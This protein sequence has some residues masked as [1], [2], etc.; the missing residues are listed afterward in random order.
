L[1]A[2]MKSNLIA[3]FAAIACGSAAAADPQIY[4]DG[5]ERVLPQARQSDFPSNPPSA[6]LAWSDRQ[7]CTYEANLLV[8]AANN[9]DQGTRQA[10]TERIISNVVAKSGRY[11][12][13][14][15]RSAPSR[16][17]W[18]YS[19]PWARGPSIQTSYL[20]ECDPQHY[21]AY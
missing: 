3:L 18:I 13:Q 17:D 20:K 11:S 10:D 4:Q 14:F 2:I 19:N 5:Q 9:R 8:M 7:R 21:S 12:A 15:E 6:A 16:I 1:A